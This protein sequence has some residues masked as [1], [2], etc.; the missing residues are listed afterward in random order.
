MSAFSTPSKQAPS[1]STM[2]IN[3]PFAELSASIPPAV[4]QSYVVIMALLVIGGTLFDIA[5]KKSATYF[6]DNWRNSR[7]KAKQQVGG[8]AMVGLAA[9]TAVVDV[10]ASGEFC[11][12]RRRVAHL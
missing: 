11:N 3:N 1:D 7:S 5:H 9:Q 10:M 2:L 12:M 8:A 6:F 4:M